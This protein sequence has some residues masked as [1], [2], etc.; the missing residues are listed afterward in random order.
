MYVPRLPAHHSR[1]RLRVG[2]ITLALVLSG[3]ATTSVLPTT[4]VAPTITTGA[5]T[6]SAT[7]PTRSAPASTPATPRTVTLVANGDLLWHNTVWMSA[8]AEAKRT[9]KGIDGFDFDPMF[10]ALKPIISGADV[11]ICH[12][13]VPFSAKGGP[14]KNYPVFAAPPEI[15]TWIK[16]MG[17]DAC[18][19][20]SNHSVDAGVTGLIRTDT[21]LE[22]A[23]VD[24]VGTFRSA[25]ER[26]TPVI[27]TTAN[28]VKVGIVSGT[29]GLNGF[30]LPSDEKWAVSFLTADNILAQA[31]AARRA[32]ADIVVVDMHDG[33][34]YQVQ[35]TTEQVALAKTLT[36]SDDVDLVIGEHVHVIQPVTKM[37]GKW[38]VYGMGN[39]I[40]Q[41]PTTQ[42]RTYEGLTMRFTF[43]GTAGGRY[44]VSKASYIGTYFTNGDPI[45]VYPVVSSLASGTGPTARLQTARTAIAASVNLLGNND[46]LIA[47]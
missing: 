30:T 45:R 1:H 17:W 40:A 6:A 8:Q 10:A 38:V 11:A 43:T 47:S 13:E 3:C 28:G 25:A 4:T 41:Q 36:A 21:A 35:P 22:Q 44:T 27:Y 23:G 7:A 16:S 5:T 24:Y 26:A 12:E 19:N 15:A 18:T 14:Y 34:E 37:N 42:P 20:A 31:K 46:G 9:G 39:L 33:N 29:Y 2:F 32:G